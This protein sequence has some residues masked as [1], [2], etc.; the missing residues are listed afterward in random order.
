MVGNLILA[1]A[2][3]DLTAFW[4]RDTVIRRRHA[5]SFGMSNE[6]VN[7][8]GC[9]EELEMLGGTGFGISLFAKAEMQILTTKVRSY[10]KKFRFLRVLSDLRGF[11][12]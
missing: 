11:R 12:V 6:T 5:G 9:E 4:D 1:F 3:A 2:V 7:Y 8:N 10:T